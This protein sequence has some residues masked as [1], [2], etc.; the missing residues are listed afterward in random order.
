MA[1]SKNSPALYELIAR[2]RVKGRPDLRTS[3]S[4]ARS[5]A[6]KE[7]VAPKVSPPTPPRA[8]PPPRPKPQPHPKPRTDG[9][10]S[11][12]T[13]L[14]ARLPHDPTRIT[15]LICAAAILSFGVFVVVKWRQGDLPAVTSAAPATD[16]ALD[17][18][19]EA[20]TLFA[21]APTRTDPPASDSSADSRRT[22]MPEPVTGP[23]TNRPTAAASS[24]TTAAAPKSRQTGLN[25]VVVEG[26]AADRRK[27]AD[28]A[29]AFLAKNGIACTIE[30]RS[31]GGWYVVTAEGHPG[32]DPRLDKLVDR[33]RALG[34]R[35]FDQGGRYRFL[36]FAKRFDGSGW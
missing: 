1:K 14:A 13:R 31:G 24:S 36:C 27:D 28:D 22:R 7:F 8:A 35:Y 29:V 32:R 20:L 3:G 2:D 34:A 9:R 4:A 11:L 19:K 33:I 18:A 30:K 25:Y 21:S 16:P 10:E 17:H 23:P 5:V 15:A 6:Q 12:L 26:F